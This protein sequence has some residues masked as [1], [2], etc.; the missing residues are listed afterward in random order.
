MSKVFTL[1]L[2]LCVYIHIYT[3]LHK[4]TYTNTRPRVNVLG[5]VSVSVY[6]I[7]LM[8]IPSCKSILISCECIPKP[9][10]YFFVM[11]QF[12]WPFTKNHDTLILSKHQHFLPIWDYGG[13]VPR[14]ILNVHFAPPH[15][16]SRTSI[17]NFVHGHFWPKLL[18]ELRY[19]L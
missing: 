11:G 1:T 9:N 3:H 17:P 12:D 14:I 4:A 2:L 5:H 13:V 16:S 18:R 8:T 6:Y 19:F 10:Y 15:C 7:L